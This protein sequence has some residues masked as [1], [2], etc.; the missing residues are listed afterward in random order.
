MS[1]TIT[2][3]PEYHGVYAKNTVPKFIIETDEVIYASL[4]IQG[5]TFSVQYQPDFNDKVEIDFSQIYADYLKTTMP[6][7]SS[8][9]ISQQNT[10]IFCEASFAGSV[11]GQIAYPLGYPWEWYVFNAT[12]NSATAFSTWCRTNF[13]TNQP[14]EKYT[15]CDSPEWLTWVDYDTPAGRKLKAILYPSTGG[16]E[17]QQLATY[18]VGGCKTYNVSYN[19]VIATAR[20]LPGRYKG[21]YDIILTDSSNNE[22][23]RQR[24]IY[25]ER[26][27]KEHYYLFTNALGGVDTL[28]CDGENVLAPETTHNIGRFDL[29]YKALDDADNNRKWSQQTGMMPHRWRSWLHELLTSKRG[30]SLYDA[31]NLTYTDIVITES[32]INMSDANQLASASFSYMMAQVDSVMAD[33][34]RATDRSLHQSVADEGEAMEDLTEGVVAEFSPVEGGQGYH[35]DELE[36]DAT[37]LY[38]IFPQTEQH[39][40]IS[41]QIK[42]ATYTFDPATDESPLIIDKA[43]HAPIQFTMADNVLPELEI[44]YYPIS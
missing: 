7:G 40:T 20:Y 16:S 33:T 31:E 9:V 4:T 2:Q 39:T 35:T 26:S 1:V 42:G 13:L 36:I 30:T 27:G 22:L 14:L 17:T 21:Y 3:R 29:Q 19:R 24:Y 10:S 5:N 44:R 25:H 15:T 41:Y 38:V 32:E 12:L 6:D 37:K 8:H 23:A 43:H 11:T 28:V 34:E 18:N